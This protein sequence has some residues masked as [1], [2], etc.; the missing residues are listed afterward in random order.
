MVI[1]L[2]Q[3]YDPNSGEDPVLKNPWSKEHFN[4]TEQGKLIREN[5]VQAREL[6]ETAGIT[7]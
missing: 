7:I 1:C 3:K 5:P 4:L 2:K 6:A